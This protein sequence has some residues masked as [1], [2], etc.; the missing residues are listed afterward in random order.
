M[1]VINLKSEKGQNIMEYALLVA[2]V[3]AVFVVM[4]LY[5]QRA[6]NAKVKGVWDAMNLDTGGTVTQYEPYYASQTF[7]T[8]QDAQ[9]KEQMAVGGVV[10][11]T[12]QGQGEVT[13]R[14]GSATSGDAG[15]LASD[16]AWK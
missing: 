2:L 6:M 5:G 1:R 15:T 11:R 12:L 13:S 14:T 10:T 16:D 4:R 7:E 3:V 9:R 8:T